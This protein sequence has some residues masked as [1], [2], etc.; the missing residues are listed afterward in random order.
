M[1]ALATIATVAAGAAAVIGAGATIYN[2]YQQQKQ[3]DEQKTATAH[4]YEV[5]GRKDFAAAQRDA[6]EKRL[7]GELLLSRQ[8]AAAA[9]SGGGA[10]GD[11]PTIVRL[12][13]ETAQK[14]EY[15]AQTSMY[16]GYD[17][18][19][20]ADESASNLRASQSG[21]FVGSLISGLGELIGGA[22][23]TANVADR[24]GLLPKA[25]TRWGWSSLPA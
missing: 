10:G 7:Q 20:T 17:A 25:S 23:N 3:F 24:Y 11:D 12:M 2:G 19:A 6:I 18:K 9:A 4:A 15:A 1:A 5:A 14:T 8:Q 21:S 22:A 13:T 16:R